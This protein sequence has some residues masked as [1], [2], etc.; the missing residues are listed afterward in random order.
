[1]YGRDGLPTSLHPAPSFG[2][3]A[4]QSIKGE[5]ARSV[6]ILINAID[7]P[8]AP[9]KL[10]RLPDSYHT[11]LAD[12]LE[13]ERKSIADVEARVQSLTRKAKPVQTAEQ[14]L[15]NVR[16]LVIDDSALARRLIREPLEALH[17]TVEEADSGES[18]LEKYTLRR[19]DII[20]MDIVMPGVYGM[21]ILEKLRQFNPDVRV[22]MVSA[23][24]QDM[25]REKARSLGATS[26]LRK[27]VRAKNLQSAVAAA[28]AGKAWWD[29]PLRAE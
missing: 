1:M 14:C 7:N 2:W 11:P 27:P 4:R 28:L 26:I 19:H 6:Q 20:T 29:E 25:T 21:E 23:D 22:I 3:T 9:F 24:I 13:N 16:V 8:T 5:G 17:Y 18:G 12:R 10:D 15:K